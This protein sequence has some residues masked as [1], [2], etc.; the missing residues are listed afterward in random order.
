MKRYGRP[1]RRHRENKRMRI[2]Y[3]KYQEEREA[4]F[5]KSIEPFFRVMA[6]RAML[7]ATEAIFPK[8]GIVSDAI[9]PQVDGGEFVIPCRDKS[10]TRNFEALGMSAKL[11]ASSVEK[12]RDA[13]NE[14]KGTPDKSDSNESQ[15]SKEV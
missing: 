4:A 3:K 12:L 7:K 14:F 9:V 8:G 2:A 5:V 10:V 1:R 11:A 6:F 15:A 13:I